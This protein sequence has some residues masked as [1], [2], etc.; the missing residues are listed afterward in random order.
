M[1]Q[2]S[3][4]NVMPAKTAQYDQGVL[5]VLA[6]GTVLYKT[7][8]QAEQAHKQKLESQAGATKSMPK[9]KLG[10]QYLAKDGQVVPYNLGGLMEFQ[11]TGLIVVI[12]VLAGLSLICAGVGRLI[13]VFGRNEAM[14]EAEPEVVSARLPIANSMHS[15]LTDQQL[16]VLLTAAATEII[17][18][19]VRIE[20]FRHLEA[21]GPSWSE[22]GRSELLHS[23]RLNRTERK[24]TP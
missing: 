14:R 18:S 11:L 7:Y 15:S 19:P 24:R 4:V 21:R 8:Q 20:H 1:E 17:G 3:P 2:T 13:R 12:V 10:E 22:Q 6:D 9:A 16:V 23:H 5:E